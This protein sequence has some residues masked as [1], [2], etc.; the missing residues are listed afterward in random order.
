MDL[1]TISGGLQVPQAL[2]V[3]QHYLHTPELFQMAKNIYGRESCTR[4]YSQVLFDCTKGKAGEFAV[5]TIAN[6]G[7]IIKAEPSPDQHYLDRS[8][9]TKF[10]SVANPLD[11]ALIEVKTI[12]HYRKYFEFML[13]EGDGALSL[14]HFLNSP[15]T[16][17][18]VVTYVNIISYEEF[19]VTPAYVFHRDAFSQKYLRKS[20]LDGKCDSYVWYDDLIAAG[21]C[22][23]IQG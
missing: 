9:D 2:I 6:A 20:K 14:R 7:S 12:Y 21:L 17:F 8:Y 1:Q 13:D 19:H 22:R 15:N 11:F 16:E 18:L 5:N 4:E 3:R 23:K 10:I